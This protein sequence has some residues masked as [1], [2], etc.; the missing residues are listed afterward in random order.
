MCTAVGHAEIRLVRVAMSSVILAKISFCSRAWASALSRMVLSCLVV[1][2]LSSRTW[3]DV[4]CDGTFVD[5]LEFSNVVGQGSLLATDGRF[6]F[7]ET[8]CVEERDF[9]ICE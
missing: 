8:G 9:V 2:S 6:K 7:I 3:V 4:S 1:S 5:F